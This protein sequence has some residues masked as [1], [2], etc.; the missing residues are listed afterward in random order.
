MNLYYYY[1]NTKFSHEEW[2]GTYITN[3]Q[4]LNKSD[5]YNQCVGQGLCGRKKCPTQINGGWH[6]SFMGD[7]KNVKFKTNNYGHDSSNH[8]TE[9]YFKIRI[10]KLEDPFGRTQEVKFHSLEKLEKLP[11]YVQ[12][13]TEKFKKYIY[14]P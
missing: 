6:I 2:H 4:S 1:I 12:N 8:L 5:I 10:E 13:N 3:F 14:T 11:S 9:E 7:A